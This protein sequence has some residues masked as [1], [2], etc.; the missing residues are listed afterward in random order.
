M[1]DTVSGAKLGGL[2][3]SA[4][5]AGILLMAP[6]HAVA[7]PAGA[8]GAC[9]VSPAKMSD[10]EVE[11]FIDNPPG[12]LTEFPTGGLALSTRIRA[13]AGSSAAALDPIMSLAA[14]ASPPQIAALGS[15]L[16]RAARSCASSNP[17]YAALIQEKVALLNNKELALAFES[18]LNDV[19][20]AA[21]G[22]GGAA[23]GGGVSGIGGGGES[24]GGSLSFLGGGTS[25]PT[26]PGFSP[27]ARTSSN[28]TGTTNIVV[29]ISVGAGGTPSLS[30]SN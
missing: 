13:L 18:A 1:I 4:M 21:L 17:E 28:D 15:G 20:T 27:R 12:L 5:T 26:A 14:S 29:N 25:T 22:P 6:V 24:A 19:Q 16:A 3:A 11:S 8:G 10:S 2:I 9:F 30:P 7:A 23:A